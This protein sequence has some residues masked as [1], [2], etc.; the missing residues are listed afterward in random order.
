METTILKCSLI[1]DMAWRATLSG[2]SGQMSEFYLSKAKLK[3]P[4]EFGGK[5]TNKLNL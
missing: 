1:D 2:I 4:L 5:N 3:G